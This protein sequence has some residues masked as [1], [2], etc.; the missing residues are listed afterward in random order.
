M[1]R[2]ASVISTQD[3]DKFVVR[4][5]DEMR[6]QISQVARE[7]HR[8]MNSEIVIRSDRSLT[9]EGMLNSTAH[10]LDNAELTANERE[11]LMQ[12]RQLT[13]RQQNALIALIDQDSPAVGTGNH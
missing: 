10:R 9:Q 8:S 1:P 13:H 7:N 6:E 3:C 5:P 12:F 11:L 2:I 4:F